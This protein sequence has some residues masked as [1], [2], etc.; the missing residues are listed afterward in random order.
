MMQ[1]VYVVIAVGLM[2]LI[3]FGGVSYFD[4]DTPVRAV[5]T[6]GLAAQYESIVMGMKAYSSVNNGYQPDSIARFKGYLPGGEVPGFG[7][8]GNGY[9]WSVEK[10]DGSAK[11]VVCLK[12]AEGRGASLRSAVLF[13]RSVMRGGSSAVTIGDG[14]ASGDVLPISGGYPTP[15]PAAFLTFSEN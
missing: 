3:T 10:P 2:A 5:A 4:A 13:A 14:C 6:R 7:N 1:I 9:E 11:P 8:A 15:A 12:V